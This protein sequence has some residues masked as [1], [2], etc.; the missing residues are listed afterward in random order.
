[1][2]PGCRVVVLEDEAMACGKFPLVV[3]IE[4]AV[5]NRD[6]VQS[7]LLQCS[8]DLQILC[9]HIFV[10]SEDLFIAIKRGNPQTLWRLDPLIANILNLLSAMNFPQLHII[11]RSW[12]RA[13]FSLANLNTSKHDITL[14]H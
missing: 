4:G 12:M 10:A 7:G 14:F 11:P 13:A 9:K 8:M 5:W 6:A 3:V 2:E 1:M